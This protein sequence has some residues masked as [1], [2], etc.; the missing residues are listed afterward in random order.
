[1]VIAEEINGENFEDEK[2]LFEQ[3][4]S[5]VDSVFRGLF[6][7]GNSIEIYGITFA[8]GVQIGDGFVLQHQEKLQHYEESKTVNDFKDWRVND[9][10]NTEN[11]A[12]TDCEDWQEHS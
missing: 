8:I 3:F 10:K 9:G 2:E 11:I 12:K 5:E 6:F 4:C 1:L 7:R